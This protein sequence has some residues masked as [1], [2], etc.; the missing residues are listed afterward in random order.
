MH[1]VIVIITATGS[2]QQCGAVA[3]M[4]FGRHLYGMAVPSTLIHSDEEFLFNVVTNHNVSTT[5]Q[6]ISDK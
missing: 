5:E 6:S 4:R 3:Y 2:L 1:C